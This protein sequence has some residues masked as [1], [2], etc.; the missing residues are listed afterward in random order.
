MMCVE[1]L[2]ISVLVLEGKY[3]ETAELKLRFR[4]WK[5]RKEH[6]ALKPKWVSQL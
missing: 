3:L 1:N 5:L 6:N 4:L 2:N